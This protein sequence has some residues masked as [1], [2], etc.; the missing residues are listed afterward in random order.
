MIKLIT[1]KFLMKTYKF[2]KI[3][4]ILNKILIFK[5]K[6]NN[7][8]KNKINSKTKNKNKFIIMNLKFETKLIF[9]S[10]LVRMNK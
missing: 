1:N 5:F 4:I 2:Y 7:L 10:T 9:P 6:I 8:Y 3:M